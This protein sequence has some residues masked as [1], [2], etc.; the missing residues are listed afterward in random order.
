MAVQWFKTLPSNAGGAGLISGWG[1]KILP[2]SGPKNQNIKQKQY[3]NKCNKDCK[4]KKKRRIGQP[5]RKVGCEAS[6]D[7]PR[8]KAHERMYVCIT[9]SL[10]C[11]SETKLTQCRKSTILQL[12]KT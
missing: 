12:K 4:K 1:A 9:E 11:T 5:L 3:C 10:C 8:M 6:E 7:K 2:A